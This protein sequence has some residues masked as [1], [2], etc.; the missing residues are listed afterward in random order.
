MSEQS[1]S[2]PAIVGEVNGSAT[3]YKI[4]TPNAQAYFDKCVREYEDRLLSESTNIEAME[5]TGSGPPEV[6]AAHIEEAK[7]VLIRRLRRRTG[8]SKRVAALRIGQ[9]LM[10]A[11]VGIG[12]SNFNTTWGALMCVVGILLFSMLLMIEREVVRD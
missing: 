1:E 3:V 7:W 12:S 5:H 8:S 2:L 11:V 6:T 9:I 10:S 4:L